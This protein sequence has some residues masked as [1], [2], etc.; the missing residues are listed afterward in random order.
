M[1]EQITVFVENK[2]GRITKITRLLTENSIN[3]RALVIQDRG[4][5]G[6]VKM[7]TDDP[8]KTNLVLNEAGFACALKPVLAVVIDDRPGGLL[9]LTETLASE[10]I[11]IADAYGF[12]VEPG[13]KAVFCAETDDI[14]RIQ[15]VLEGRGF[16]MMEGNE[17][18]GG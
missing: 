4:Q 6:L 12:V 16:G 10:N 14:G 15:K 7:I 11:N 9:K 2:P 1:T 5:F 8:K 17:I 18:Y 13:K 3:L